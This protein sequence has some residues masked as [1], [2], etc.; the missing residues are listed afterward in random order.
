M[1]VTT[2]LMGVVP[3]V[4]FVLVDSFSGV[5]AGIIWALLFA[6]AELVYTLVV[7]RTV[8]EI[9][10]ISLGTVLLFGFLSYKSGNSFFFKM[11]P[12]ILG[13]LFGVLMLVMQAL[14]KPLLVI[15]TEK[16]Q[17]LMPSELRG[18]LLDPFFLKFLAKCSL[19]LGVGFLVHAGLVAYAALKMSN[20]WWLALR[21]LGVYV[22]MFLSMLIARLL[23]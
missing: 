22:M 15:L 5:K 9:T 18:R 23:L 6:L 1:N 19:T 7:Y 20:W 3:L 16:Y 12:V 8:D 14:G 13:V 2:F 4:V 11:Q 21:G 10:V 17:Y